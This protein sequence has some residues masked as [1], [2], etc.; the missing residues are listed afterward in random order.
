MDLGFKFRNFGFRVCLSLQQFTSYNRLRYANTRED[1]A[2]RDIAID[3]ETESY[4]DT[5]TGKNIM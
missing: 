3:K 1:K 5:H 4:K 2:Y